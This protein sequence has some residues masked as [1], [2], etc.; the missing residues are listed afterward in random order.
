MTTMSSVAEHLKKGRLALGLTVEQIAETTKVRTDH[1]RAIEE[2]NYNVFS[3]P[4]YIRGFVR[5]YA[6]LLKL[7]VQEVMTALDGELGQT[8]KF[9][10]HPPLSNEP[11]GVMDFIT[12]QLSKL[13]WRKGVIGVVLLVALVVFLIGYLIWHHYHTADPL[14]SL[15]PAVYRAPQSGETLPLP[16]PNSAPRR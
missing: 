15:Q 16:S 5:G 8:K 12:L 13:D 9:A 14:K 1:I 7:D 11:R 10:D 6:K 2:G 3:A 4:V